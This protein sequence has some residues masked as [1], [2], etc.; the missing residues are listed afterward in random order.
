VSN[1]PYHQIDRLFT[2]YKPNIHL[3]KQSVSRKILFKEANYS[4]F[5][6]F[7]MRTLK[8]V[9]LFASLVLLVG[10]FSEKALAFPDRREYLPF[11]IAL[12]EVY[13]ILFKITATAELQRRSGASCENGLGTCKDFCEALFRLP[14][15]KHCEKGEMCCFPEVV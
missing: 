6:N 2:L 11:F 14:S 15:R 3:E 13:F 5:I 8:S 12:I 1:H 9:C 7:V 10:I 4:I